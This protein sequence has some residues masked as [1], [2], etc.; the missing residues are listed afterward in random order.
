MTTLIAH[1]TGN[2][3]FLPGIAPYS[4]GVVADPGFEVVH[5]ALQQP[6]D[7]FAGFDFV[8]HFL[9][10]QARPRAA[11]CAM[12]L[13]SPAPFTMPGFIDFNRQYCAVLESWG[14]FVE[15]ENPIARTNVAP[16]G[17]NSSVPQLV[18]FSFVRPNPDL[19]RPTWIVAGAGELLEGTLV[20]EG[21]IRRGET[22]GDAILEKARYV[23]QVMC[24]RLAGLGGSW[25]DVSQVSAYTVHSLERVLTE[26]LL[27]EMPAAASRGVRWLYAQ[28]PVIDIEFEMDLHGVAVEWLV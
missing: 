10:Q 21:I 2:Y 6:R 1:P 15:G 28:P 18:G 24:A 12:E 23:V 26:L 13:R 27:P 16:V 11:L 17:W 4:C 19:S 25:S 20:D 7:W 9:R 22:S 14:V 5:V 3:R 8:E